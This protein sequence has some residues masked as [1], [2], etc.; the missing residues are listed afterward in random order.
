MW[1]GCRGYAAAADQI[2]DQGSGDLRD[3]LG[4]VVRLAAFQVIGEVAVAARERHRVLAQVG[5]AQRRYA[6][7]VRRKTEL[8]ELPFDVGERGQSLAKASNIVL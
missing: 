2:A 4:R 6:L 1:R 8:A 7:E 3:D 5:E